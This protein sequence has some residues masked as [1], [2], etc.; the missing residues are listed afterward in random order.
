MSCFQVT[1]FRERLSRVTYVVSIGNDDR[2]LRSW[3][4]MILE[5]STP[6]TLL[7]LLT[8][9]G[10]TSPVR[11]VAYA[12]RGK[13]IVSGS[14]NAEVAVWE[15]EDSNELVWKTQWHDGAILSIA[16][17]GEEI[18]SSSED[19]TIRVWDLDTGG[20]K[21]IIRGHTAPISAIRLSPDGR[22][23]ISASGSRMRILDSHTG[24]EYMPPRPMPCRIISIAMSRDGDFIACCGTDGQVHIWCPDME[25]PV[26][27]PDSL[28][29]RTRGLEYCPVDDQGVHV[30]ATLQ[31]D[32]WLLG[33]TDQ[34]MCWI[35]PAHRTGLLMERSEGIL[36]PPATALDVRKFVHGTKWERCKDDYEQLESFKEILQIRLD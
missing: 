28:I 2:T 4:L 35:P 5:G 24:Q 14:D 9:R 22:W 11:T 17:A 7:P 13:R 21:S 27:W 1:H 26:T 33:S 10:H 12:R 34:V 29:R 25:A 30:S 3:G 32:G 20:L 15:G 18:F 16:V 8:Y 23:I 31:D 36:G 6:G 19:K